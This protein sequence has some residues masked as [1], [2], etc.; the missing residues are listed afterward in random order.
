M[1]LVVVVLI[2]VARVGNAIRVMVLAQ[3]VAVNT[4]CKPQKAFLKERQVSRVKNIETKLEDGGKKLVLIIDLNQEFGPSSSGKSVT[5]A[6]T[7][8]NV[9]VPGR[10]EIKMGINIYKP[11]P[12]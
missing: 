7:E 8:G 1:F 6:S 12:K 3:G 2:S 10:E 4:R 5:V 9:A 11:R